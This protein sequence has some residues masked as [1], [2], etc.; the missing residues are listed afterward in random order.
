MDA[1]QIH[2]GLKRPFLLETEMV[3]DDVKRHH[4]GSAIGRLRPSPARDMAEASRVTGDFP[5]GLHRPAIAVGD[6]DL[7]FNLADPP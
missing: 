7:G 3:G 5:Q 4:Q 2:Q 1:T 6:P